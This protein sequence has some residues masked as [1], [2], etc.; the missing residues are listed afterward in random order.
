MLSPEVYRSKFAAACTY[1][2]YLET[3]KPH[4]QANWNASQNRVRLTPDQTALITSFVRTIKILVI[5]GTWC[6]DCVQQG[7]ILDHIT[8][9]GSVMELR[10][11]DRDENLDLAEPLRICGGLRVPTVL[12]LNEDF[13]FVSILGDRTLGR[14]RRVAAK[15]LGASCPLPSAALE[16][17]ETAELVQDWL[18]E[19]ER[20]HLILRLSPKL[21]TRYDD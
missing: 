8:R 10:F 21:R 6:G 13:E 16:A 9:A 7:P 4:E 12:F 18:N 14:Y 20:V 15:Q 17:E 1:A 11:L 5:S 2:A 3:A 19:F